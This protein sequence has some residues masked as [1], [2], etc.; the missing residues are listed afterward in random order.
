MGSLGAL[1]LSMPMPGMPGPSMLPDTE[2]IPAFGGKGGAFAGEGADLAAFGGKGADL[3]AF[4]GKGSELAAFGGKGS[5]L[6]EFA[7]KGSDLAPFGGKGFDLS[8]FPGKG[9]DLGAFAGKGADLAAL[10]GKGSDLLA[11]SSNGAALAAL[12]SK[13]KDLAALAGKGSKLGALKGKG[14]DFGAFGG[15]G[16]DPL[17]AGPRIPG[18]Q[19]KGKLQIPGIQLPPGMPKLPL[20]PGMVPGAMLAPGMMPPGAMNEEF[21]AQLR[22]QQ[23]A[24]KFDDAKNN[25]VDPQVKELCEYHSLDDRCVQV[26]DEQMKQ[27]KETFE[28]DMQALWVHLEGA[29]NPSGKLMMKLKEMRMGVFKGMTALD[30]TIQEFAK[31]NRLD[32]QAAVKLAEAMENR[33]DLEG[34]LAKLA[35]HFERSNKPSSLA[36]MM[37]RDL[38]EGKPVKDPEY[39][40]AI[41]SKIHEKEVR[42]QLKER[43]NRSRSRERGSRYDDGRGERGGRDYRDRDRDRG[44]R[45]DRGGGGRDYRDREDRRDRDRDDRGQRRDYDGSRG[46]SSR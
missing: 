29:K 5:D 16:S 20:G 26:L 34:D 36:M 25:E 41:G 17:Q 35:K 9:A 3:A 28:S 38:R 42:E 40:A 30:K 22:F 27:R 23:V 1:G 6:A 32:A 15:K 8:A 13:G 18:I 11:S 7:G 21:M 39:T 14:L 46:G 33:T 12:A 37:L 31:K 4:A 19:G 43:K 24:A 45:G 44:D 2:A 10:A